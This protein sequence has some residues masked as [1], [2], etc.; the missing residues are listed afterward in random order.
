MPGLDEL[1]ISSEGDRVKFEIDGHVL[2]VG[3]EESLAIL[4]NVV[5]Q[6]FSGNGALFCIE[7]KY[8]ESCDRK[9]ACSAMGRLCIAVGRFPQL[10]EVRVECDDTADYFLMDTADSVYQLAR[11]AVNAVEQSDC[12]E[13]VKFGASI[14]C[15][16]LQ[17]LLEPIVISNMVESDENASEESHDN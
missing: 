1:L 6:T 2:C 17:M 10:M 15:T 9:S 12:S 5:K 11:V 3:A 14:V 8:C 13:E 7:Q 16:A 4:D